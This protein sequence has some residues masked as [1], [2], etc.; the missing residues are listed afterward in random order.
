MKKLVLI[1]ELA[2]LALA[3]AVLLP[4]GAQAA[5]KP[6]STVTGTITKMTSD[7]LFLQTDQGELKFDL[8]KSTVKPATALAVGQKVTISYDSDDQGKHEMDARKIDMF[9][10]P[11]TQTETTPP[12]TETTPPPTQ[13][14]TQTYTPPS[15]ENQTTTQETLPKTASPL[16]LMGLTGL[17]SLAGSALLLKQGK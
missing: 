1:S 17:L 3:V 9:T 4:M 8:N 10:E 13:T 14:Q 12:P 16:P 5:D 7:D 11:T 15:Q 6:Q 2:A